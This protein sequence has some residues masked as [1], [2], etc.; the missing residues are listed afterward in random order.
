MVQAVVGFFSVTERQ[1]YP[2]NAKYYL[3][4]DGLDIGYT[5]RARSIDEFTVGCKYEIEQMY[6]VTQMVKEQLGIK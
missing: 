4:L 3:G 2:V 6:K 1:V 5:S